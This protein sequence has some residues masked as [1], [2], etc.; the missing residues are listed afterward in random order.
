MLYHSA[1]TLLVLIILIAIIFIYGNS[2]KNNIKLSRLFHNEGCIPTKKIGCLWI[3]EKNRKWGCSTTQRLFSY[4]EVL[5]FDI[6]VD[7][8][9]INEESRYSFYGG[10]AEIAADRNRTFEKIVVIVLVSDRTV[11]YVNIPVA[12]S[13]VLNSPVE[14]ERNMKLAHLICYEL[15]R[16]NKNI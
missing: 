10:T 16:M 13:S 2:A 12:V 15:E 7:G 5:G 6:Q 9:S 14:Y 11:K 4:S 1:I 3:D 8:V